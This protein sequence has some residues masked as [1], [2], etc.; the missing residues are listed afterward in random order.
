M[1]G[2]FPKYAQYAEQ[3]GRELPVAVLEMLAS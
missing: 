2:V 3:A 1:V